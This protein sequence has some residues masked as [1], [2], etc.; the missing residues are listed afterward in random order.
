MPTWA[1][2]SAAAAATVSAVLV[3]IAVGQVVIGP[4]SDA[5]GRRVPLLL[6]GLGYAVAHLLSALAPNDHASCSCCAC[7]RDWRRP[8]ASW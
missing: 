1:R 3:G 8:P 6:G 5:V 2:R 7:S 4:L